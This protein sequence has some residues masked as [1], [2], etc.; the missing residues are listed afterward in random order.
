MDGGGDEGACGRV[1]DGDGSGVSWD[2]FVV[3][4]EAGGLGVGFAVGEGDFDGEGGG[5]GHV[6]SFFFLLLVWRVGV[7]ENISSFPICV[8]DVNRR[9]RVESSRACLSVCLVSKSK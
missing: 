6:V 4:E 7:R 9:R 2:E 5:G 8:R 1:V 3:D